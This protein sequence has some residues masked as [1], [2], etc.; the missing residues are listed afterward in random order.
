[1][2]FRE[3]ICNS[4]GV[5]NLY[6]CTTAMVG[7]M[8][9]Y[10]YFTAVLFGQAAVIVGAYAL[11]HLLSCSINDALL[12]PSYCTVVLRAGSCSSWGVMH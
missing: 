5:M 11:V 6:S 3:D 1:V 7:V 10:N 12:R 4:S 8:H 9:W 2:L